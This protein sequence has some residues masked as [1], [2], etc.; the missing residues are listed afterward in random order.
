MYED[1]PLNLIDRESKLLTYLCSVMR[2]NCFRS[3]SGAR[4]HTC[5]F[6]KIPIMYV[7]FLTFLKTTCFECLLVAQRL[8]ASDFRTNCFRSRSGARLHTFNFTKIPIVYVK[9]LTFLKT[10]CFECLLV[11][12]RLSAS[13]FRTTPQRVSWCI[14][15]QNSV[16]PHESGA[17]PAN[18]STNFAL[19]AT[20]RHC[21]ILLFFTRDWRF[22]MVSSKFRKR[23]H[24]IAAR[25]GCFIT[26]VGVRGL[27][28]AIRP[29]SRPPG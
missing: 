15:Q 18:N 14:D 16:D 17:V 28:S 22:D 7:K 9:F 20:V 19:V 12:Q 5:N 10:T 25:V 24:S 6:T 21:A 2:W 27:C 11:A 8:S 4:L 23:I 26:P 13:D 3:R 29:K 1:S